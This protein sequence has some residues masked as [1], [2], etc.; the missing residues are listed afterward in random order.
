MPVR[1][2]LAYM[3][4]VCLLLL[5][6]SGCGGMSGKGAIQDVSDK[7]LNLAKAVTMIRAGLE[8][9]ARHYLVLV[10]D[11]SWESGVTDEALFRL[12]LLKINDGDLGGGKSSLALLDKLRNS[13]PKS[14]WTKQAAPLHSYLTG[15]K[16]IRNRE[17]E[18]RDKNLSLSRDV[19]DLRQ[20][21][22]RLKS[23]DLELEQKIKR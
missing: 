20:M 16:N 23:L 13:Y 21:I 8:S 9:E 18:L 14:V 11:D 15:L 22:E 19:R 10:I 7:R 3:M 6:L 5:I 2:K 17:S 1:R 12:A 4:P